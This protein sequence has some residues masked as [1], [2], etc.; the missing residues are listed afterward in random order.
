MGLEGQNSKD[1][2]PVVE[3]YLESR[4]YNQ[5]LFEEEAGEISHAPGEDAA[6]F[7]V[8]SMAGTLIGYHHAQF[9]RGRYRLLVEPET[10]HLPTFYG[11]SVDFEML[12]DTGEVILVEGVFDRAAIKRATR[13]GWAVLARLSKGTGKRQLEFLTRYANKV[14]LSFDLDRPGLEARATAKK[15]LVA[16]G[17]KVAEIMFPG[18]DPAHALERVGEPLLKEGVLRQLRL[19]SL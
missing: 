16:G 14:W 13:L 17:V 4:G 7:A 15:R 6:R 5:P 19:H 11:S 9:D 10:G 1:L 18:L 12:Y 8:R 2:D 3:S